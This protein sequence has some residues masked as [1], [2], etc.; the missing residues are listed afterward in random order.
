M[1]KCLCF[2]SVVFTLPTLW[3]QQEPLIIL[4]FKLSFLLNGLY[5]LKLKKKE[6]RAD[7][8]SIEVVWLLKR[9]LLVCIFQLPTN[10][11][12]QLD[13]LDGRLNELQPTGEVATL[14]TQLTTRITSLTTRVC[15]SYLLIYVLEQILI[16]MLK[17]LKYTKITGMVQTIRCPQPIH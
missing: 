1:K 11:N 16:P 2:I 12:Q 17:L 5:S 3:F 7:S 14:I 10:L 8:L 9:Y 6:L 15:Y 4:F 13:E